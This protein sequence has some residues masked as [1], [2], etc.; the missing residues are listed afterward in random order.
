VEEEGDVAVTESHSESLEDVVVLVVVVV[1]VVASVG[2][3]GVL[4]FKVGMG[5]RILL[6]SAGVALFTMVT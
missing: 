4:L 2:L 5:A 3:I 6:A 1:M